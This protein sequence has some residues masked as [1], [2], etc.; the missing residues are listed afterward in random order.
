MTDRELTPLG[1]LLEQARLDV[2][3]IS[4][5]EAARRAG[6]SEGRWRQ[7]VAGV[8][9]KAG[10]DVAARGTDRT[11]VAMA[12]AVGVDPAAALA[13]AGRRV[14]PEHLDALVADVQ[15]SAKP[16]PQDQGDDGLADEIERIA[17][18]PV[19]PQ[20]RRRMIQAV[21]D[22]YEEEGAGKDRQP[23]PT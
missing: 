17:R 15:A 6:M 11:V 23:R 7:I 16:A 22:L 12:L 21:I 1:R 13:A 18:L 3:R 10:A 20:A 19:S 2:L 9:R 4:G 8:E 14:L 5:R